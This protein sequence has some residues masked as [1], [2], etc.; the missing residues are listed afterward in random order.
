MNLSEWFAPIRSDRSRLS[1][2]GSTP[3]RSR[4]SLFARCSALKREGIS[5]N[6][7]WGAAFPSFH[8][9]AGQQEGLGS[10]QDKMRKLSSATSAMW[11][12]VHDQ[13]AT[14]IRRY[15]ITTKNLQSAQNR[16][17][18]NRAGSSS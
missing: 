5:L 8:H 9:V 18:I 11:E 10:F 14:S 13:H 15:C 3:S 1:W 7:G 6:Y 12:N 2:N 17:N 4:L 16:G